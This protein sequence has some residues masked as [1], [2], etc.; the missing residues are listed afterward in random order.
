MARKFL[1]LVAILI[2]LFIAGRIALAFWFQDLAKIAF[3]PSGQYEQ[4]APLAANTYA[5]KARWL[6]RPDLGAQDPSR[7]MPRQA[8]QGEAQLKVAVFFIHPTSYLSRAHW[9]APDDD[10]RSRELAEAFQRAIGSPFNRA[11]VLWAPHYRQATFG[12]FMEKGPQGQRALDAAFGDVDAAFGW[13]LEHT[14]PALPIVIAGHSQGSYHLR[15]LLAKRVNGTPLAG[16]IAAAYVIGWPVSVEHDLPLMGL[17][18]CTTP[19][20]PGCVVSWLSFAEPAETAEML[21][22]GAR[23]VGL[24]GKRLVG[25]T[26]LCTNPLTGM[27]GGT[28]DARQGL[29]SLMPDSTFRNGSIVPQL[30]GAECAADGSLRIGQGPE[31]GPFVAPGNN[32]HVY[33]IPLFWMNLRADFARRVDAWHKTH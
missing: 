22:L 7:W 29:G 21:R 23:N 14:D 33:D 2:A 4:P 13:F 16:R 30:T 20:Q 6:S 18:A 9:N 25:S 10:V 1:Y 24:D 3:V 5:D 11:S 27:A 26:I 15:R 31:M 19:E 8:P 12:A 17:P 32:Y 28:A